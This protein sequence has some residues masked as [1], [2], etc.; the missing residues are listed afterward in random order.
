LPSANS[1]PEGEP[2]AAPNTGDTVE[3][4]HSIAS[5]PRQKR[6]AAHRTE[7]RLAAVREPAPQPVKSLMDRGKHDARFQA[8]LRWQD[9][10][11]RREG[12][13]LCKGRATR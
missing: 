5:A 9:Q 13:N 8:Y 2:N 7:T 3:K 4:Q 6:I 10:Q 12:L 11:T 1:Q